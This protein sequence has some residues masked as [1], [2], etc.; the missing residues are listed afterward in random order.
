MAP[1]AYGDCPLL[2]SETAFLRKVKALRDGVEVAVVGDGV[3]R[4][5]DARMVFGMLPAVVDLSMG[6]VTRLEQGEAAGGVLDWATSLLYTHAK[7]AENFQF[8]VQPFL[9]KHEKFAVWIAQRTH[10]GTT[11]DFLSQLGAPLSRVA[12]WIHIATKMMHRTGIDKTETTQ[13]RS[14]ITA[15]EEHLAN[16]TNRIIIEMNEKK[17][18]ELTEKLPSE[19]L[20]ALGNGGGG[21]ARNHLWLHGDLVKEYTRGRHVRSFYLFSEYL[22]HFKLTAKGPSLRGLKAARN[23]MPL[24]SI[25]E[26][27]VDEARNSFRIRRDG[28]RDLVLLCDTPEERSHWV[29]T[30][31]NVL[32]RNTQEAG[33]VSMALIDSHP[34]LVSSVHSD[35]SD[36]RDLQIITREDATEAPDD[37]PS[38]VLSP[39]G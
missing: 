3:L 32:A 21:A 18:R 24:S 35:S 17:T 5:E 22:L 28:K 1:C 33:G 14:F 29:T 37:S 34:S 13:L 30:L 8:Q 26:V 2:Y 39:L 6:M 27:V 4:E 20:A 9:A 36:E 25:I 16:L 19:L 31:H 38:S 12:V 10:I 7:Y 11:R 23:V 15:A